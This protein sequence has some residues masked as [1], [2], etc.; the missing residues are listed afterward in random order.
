MPADLT[1]AE[2]HL[3]SRRLHADGMCA[4]C[5]YGDNLGCGH[6]LGECPVPG[7]PMHTDPWR[8]GDAVNLGPALLEDADLFAAM[9]APRL[10][11]ALA[12]QTFVNLALKAP[13]P[14]G[15]ENV[16]ATVG[17]VALGAAF[18]CLVAGLAAQWFTTPEQVEQWRVDLGAWLSEVVAT[19][20]HT[21][22]SMWEAGLLEDPPVADGDRHG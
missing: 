17:A 7:C 6:D 15:A 11:I 10:D 12:V 5:Y 19:S 2:C 18:K 14:P 1:C 22:L 4:A 3:P 16:E 13:P 21:N 9:D 8:I 20:I